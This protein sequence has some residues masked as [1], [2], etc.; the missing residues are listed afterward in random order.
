MKQEHVLA[1]TVLLVSILLIATLLYMGFEV[2]RIQKE[3]LNEL[4]LLRGQNQE[5]LDEWKK[6]KGE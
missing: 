2:D 1:Q 3:W 4:R 5:M 6:F